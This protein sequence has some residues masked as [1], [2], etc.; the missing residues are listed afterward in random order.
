LKLI[1]AYNAKTWALTKR[2]KRKVQAMDMKYLGCIE[3]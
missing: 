2:N 1:I 3:E